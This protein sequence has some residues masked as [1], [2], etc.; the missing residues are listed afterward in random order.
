MAENEL[1]NSS[2]IDLLPPNL[3]DDLESVMIGKAFDS[4]FD[5]IVPKVTSNVLIYS[6][7]ENLEHAVLDVLA[8]DLHV[9]IYDKNWDLDKKRQACINSEDWHLYKG[10]IGILKE[11]AQPLIGDASVKEWYEYGG[12]SFHYKALF[13]I[14][15]DF[16]T[17]NKI[18]ELNRIANKYKNLRSK[19]DGVEYIQTAKANINFLPLT[20]LGETVF[21]PVKMQQTVITLKT[22]KN[23][24]VNSPF[25]LTADDLKKFNPYLTGYVDYKCAI[26]IDN[27][28]NCSP[29]SDVEYIY[30]PKTSDIFPTFRL[31]G[32]SN[33]YIQPLP[34]DDVIIVAKKGQLNR[35][36]LFN[37]DFNW[38]AGGNYVLEVFVNKDSNGNYWAGLD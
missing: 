4:V 37:P 18:D 34:D 2:F 8:P 23:V 3:K 6:N 38:S 1:I 24:G 32:E 25:E 9:D 14:I 7:I 13:K 21:V 12:L 20:S 27:S 19:L 35:C 29:G 22:F 36:Q 33:N 26:K 28:P 16:C 10:T 30:P 17:E 5:T 11:I 31:F 15:N